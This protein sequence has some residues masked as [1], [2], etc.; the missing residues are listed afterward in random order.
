MSFNMF[1]MTDKEETVIGFWSTKFHTQEEKGRNGPEKT[2]NVADVSLRTLVFHSFNNH[3]SCN[4]C[5][6][7]C[8]QLEMQRG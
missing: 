4:V 3:M 6:T 7:F 8:H 5:P 1:E 2:C